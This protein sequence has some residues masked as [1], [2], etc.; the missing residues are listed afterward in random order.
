[1]KKIWLADAL[2][3]TVMA[4]F[5][6]VM[7]HIIKDDSESRIFLLNAGFGCGLRAAGV[8][9]DILAVSKH[10]HLGIRLKV[11]TVAAVLLLIL[12][13]TQTGLGLLAVVCSFFGVTIVFLYDLIMFVFCRTAVF[14]KKKILEN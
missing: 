2:F 11:S 7:Q 1:M 13:I 6:F 4:L 12:A 5:C 3:F 14:L 10:S 9:A 8:W